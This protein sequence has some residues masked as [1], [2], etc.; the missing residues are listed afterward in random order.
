[1]FRVYY[2]IDQWLGTVEF[3]WPFSFQIQN[4]EHLLIICDIHSFERARTL[5]P[6]N[7]QPISRICAA[8]YQEGRK[9]PDAIV[10]CNDGKQRVADTTGGSSACDKETSALDPVTDVGACA[11]Y[12]GANSIRG[13]RHQLSTSICYMGV[14][15]QPGTSECEDRGCCSQKPNVFKIVGRNAAREANA[16][17]EPK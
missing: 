13:N 10:I 3:Q 11:R 16:Q 4:Y 2:H 5:T 1:M 17:L 9:V 8:C 14:D 12:D 15:S 6:R 7:N